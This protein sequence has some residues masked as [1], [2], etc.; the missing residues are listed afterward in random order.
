[1]FSEQTIKKNSFTV[2]QI[3]PAF[4]NTSE[5]P[6]TNNSN[7]NGKTKKN[8]INS[9]ENGSVKQTVKIFPAKFN[10]ELE[11]TLIGMKENEIL[12][13]E[14]VKAKMMGLRDQ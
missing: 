9:A 4:V 11:P 3:L 14:K 10:R 1:M 2:Q 7:T 8:V 12:F 13:S 6:L 5:S